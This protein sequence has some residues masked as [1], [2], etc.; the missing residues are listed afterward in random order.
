MKKAGHG[1][2]YFYGTMLAVVA[3]STLTLAYSFIQLADEY[4]KVSHI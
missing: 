4:L 2:V 1:A 3:I